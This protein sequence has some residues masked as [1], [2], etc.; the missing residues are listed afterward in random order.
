VQ[1]VDLVSAT[2]LFSRTWGQSYFGAQTF[3]AFLPSD[4]QPGIDSGNFQASIGDGMNAVLIRYEIDVTV[5]SQGTI[6]LIAAAALP[7]LRRR[8]RCAR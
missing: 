7:T 1:R 3:T 4:F 5:P 8:R 2:A 6:G